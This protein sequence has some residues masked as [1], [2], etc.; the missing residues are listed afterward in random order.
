MKNGHPEKSLDTCTSSFLDKLF[1]HPVKIANDPK[2]IVYFALPVSVQHFTQIC[3]QTKKKL[4]SSA[5][6]QVNICFVVRPFLRTFAV[7]FPIKTGFPK[8]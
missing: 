1:S 2:C 3:T 8:L 5:Y 7:F 6:P 4:L